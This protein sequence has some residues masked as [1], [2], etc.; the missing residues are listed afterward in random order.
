MTGRWR[1]TSLRKRLLCLLLVA[2]VL[3]AL[4]QGVVAYRSARAEADE[5]F[6]YHMQQT[7]LALRAG[8]PVSQLGETG[9]AQEEEQNFDFIVQV[10][11][12]DG[13]RVFESAARADLPQRAIMGFANVPAHGTTYRVLSMQARDHVIQVAQDMATRR[14]MASAMALRTL[15]PIMVMAPILM[16]LVWWSVGH[17]LRPLRHVRQQLVQ[18]RADTLEEVNETGLPDEVQPLVHDLNLLLHR[19]RDAFEAQNNFVA[20]AAH[21][22]RSPLAA[23][24]LQAQAIQRA[25]EPA[26]RALAADRLMAGIDRATHLVEQLLVLARQ[27]A[28]PVLQSETVVLADV[29]RQ[30]I[31][32]MASEAH[33]RHIDLGLGEAAPQAMRGHPEALRILMRNLLDN[34]IKYTPQAGTV[35]VEIHL[36]GEELVLSVEDSGPGIA[37]HERARVLDRFYRVSDTPS[38]GSGLGLAIVKSI[39]DMHGARIHLGRSQRLGGLRV[40]LAFDPVDVPHA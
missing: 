26:T 9:G 19:L 2:I 24:K 29:V 40:E 38:G 3:T 27:Q 13:L 36:R 14:H 30:A 28:L 1:M 31:A 32:D 10:W 4:I 20:D 37:E 22:L 11:T 17:S 16:L 21:E 6:D 33:M 12:N 8:L 39:A 34:A 18:R 5:I 23:L 7:A 35:D 15:L 25:T